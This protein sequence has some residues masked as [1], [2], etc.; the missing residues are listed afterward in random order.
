MKTSPPRNT[1]I[2]IVTSCTLTTK[3]TGKEEGMTRG[4]RTGKIRLKRLRRAKINRADSGINST[5]LFHWGNSHDIFSEEEEN[6]TLDY[7]IC[8]RASLGN[9]EGISVA[10][11][12]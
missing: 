12:V 6:R 4:L 9:R 1:G 8:G 11:Y 3:L 5:I 2:T 10:E 7:A